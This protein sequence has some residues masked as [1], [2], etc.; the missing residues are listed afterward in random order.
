MRYREAG[1]ERITFWPLTD[2]VAQLDRLA[3]A[4]AQVGA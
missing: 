2:E 3:G 4:L 1:V